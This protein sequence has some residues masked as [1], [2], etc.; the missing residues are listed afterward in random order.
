MLENHA[1][2]VAHRRLERVLR[3]DER[4]AVVV[5]LDERGV[6]VRRVVAAGH[7][8]QDDAVAVQ[9][10]RR[11]VPVLGAVL[12]GRRHAQRLAVL[13]DHSQLVELVVEG[14]PAATLGSR[15][16]IPQRVLPA[17]ATK[18]IFKKRLD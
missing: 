6:D 1:P 2:K 17:T 12:L 13:G 8:R 7:G 10:Q 5:T 11:L 16:Q 9:R 15:P 18:Y 3:D 4:L 14:R